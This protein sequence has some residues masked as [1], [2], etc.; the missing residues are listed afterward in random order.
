MPEFIQSVAKQIANLTM[1]Y[2]DMDEIRRLML[3]VLKSK[4]VMELFKYLQKTV[5]RIFFDHPEPKVPELIKDE[6]SKKE[7][8]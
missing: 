8:N 1:D 4:E 6:P 3:N 5:L 7:G 2:V